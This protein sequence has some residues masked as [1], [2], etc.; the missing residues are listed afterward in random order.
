MTNNKN[1][2]QWRRRKSPLGVICPYREIQK[3]CMVLK[4]KAIFRCVHRQRGEPHTPYTLSGLL[5]ILIYQHLKYCIFYSYIQSFSSDF[6]MKEVVQWNFN[7]R[8]FFPRQ[9]SQIYLSHLKRRM[10][11]Q[12][13]YCKHINT[14]FP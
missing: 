11:Q 3:T 14:I 4:A 5:A 12:L 2:P 13:H 9:F 7:F 1:N 8:Q 10:S 6:L